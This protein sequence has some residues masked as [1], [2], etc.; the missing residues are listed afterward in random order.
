M[1]LSNIWLIQAKQEHFTRCHILPV[2]RQVVQCTGC[3][4]CGLSVTGV[5][6]S[7]HKSGNHLRRVHNGVTTGIFLGQLMHHHS[8]L[9]HNNLTKIKNRFK[10]LS[11]TRQF[12]LIYGCFTELWAR[13]IKNIAT[14]P[15]SQPCAGNKGGHKMG[16]FRLKTGESFL[17]GHTRWVKF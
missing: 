3:T 15:L 7:L 9:T 8:R 6:E 10:S 17:Y 4:A 11:N 5:V 1:L 13:L 16:S 2:V 12:P 14:K